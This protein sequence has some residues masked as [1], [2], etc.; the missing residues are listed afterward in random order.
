MELFHYSRGFG[1][2]FGTVEGTGSKALWVIPFLMLVLL[3]LVL[4]LAIW[5]GLGFL[6]SRVLR[7]MTYRLI[8]VTNL[9]T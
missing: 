5:L 4:K 8:R 9:L 3:A 1:D 2:I 7:L 6:Q